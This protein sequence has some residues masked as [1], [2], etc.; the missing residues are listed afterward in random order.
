MSKEGLGRVGKNGSAHEDGSSFVLP[1]AD[2][3]NIQRQVDAS[4]QE[5]MSQI[6]NREPACE[7]DE[8]RPGFFGRKIRLCNYSVD[9]ILGRP[10][11]VLAILALN[12]GTGTLINLTSNTEAES[13]PAFS[14]SL[15]ENDPHW[16]E[17]TRMVDYSRGLNFAEEQAVAHAEAMLQR[18]EA[19]EKVIAQSE[20]E[21]KAIEQSKQA[22]S[23]DPIAEK[24][25]IEIEVTINEP[26]FD[27]SLGAELDKKLGTNFSAP[28]HGA[29]RWGVTMAAA[30]A[31]N[32]TTDGLHW[33]EPDQ[34]FKVPVTEKL[35]NT[36]KEKAN[37]PVIVAASV[38]E[39]SPA[40]A[41]SEPEVLVEQPINEVEA[42]VQ[43][44]SASGEAFVVQG[45]VSQEAI[46]TIEGNSG[47]V[48]ENLT[49]SD[50][51]LE[52]F[53]AA[54]PTVEPLP[55]VEVT[56]TKVPHD[57][58]TKTP[59]VTPSP[60]PTKTKTPEPTPTGV[61]T[62][63]PTPTKAPGTCTPESSPTPTKTPEVT[64]SPTPTKT[65]TPT[66]TPTEV[67][68]G[69]P[70]VEITPTKVPHNTPTKTPERKRPTRTPSPTPTVTKT[71]TPGPTP[72]GTPKAPEYLPP[73]GEG[74]GDN[75]NTGSIFALMFLMLFAIFG[76][77]IFGLFK[78][79]SKEREEVK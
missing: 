43:T 71:E 34:E 65:K 57:T 7:T 75:D 18:E 8:N 47:L 6:P 22:L 36:I 52:F 17:V 25:G 38:V 56:P 48:V 16:A 60:T 53:A 23:Q 77:P 69:V 28:E 5:S 24:L 30:E 42:G 1:T 51:N 10:R 26:N 55:T 44:N 20:A 13:S 67:P 40:P 45:E 78:N 2:V 37:A 27:N 72:T 62:T 35:L 58:P 41:E 68:T 46:A 64:Q 66:S 29:D 14:Q 32:T 63:N 59:E 49:D 50:E 15:G 73:T 74:R 54:V 4:I 76:F 12:M 9:T 11:L 31:M 79:K 61:P 39:S 21:Q 3:L 33:V 70:T 19:R